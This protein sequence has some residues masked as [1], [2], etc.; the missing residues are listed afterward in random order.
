[1]HFHVRLDGTATTQCPAFAFG[2]QIEVID[3]IIAVVYQIS[4]ESC[5]GNCL[6][7]LRHVSQIYVQHI[8][9]T[10]FWSTVRNRLFFFHFLF[11]LRSF[12]LFGRF[13]GNIVIIGL[14]NDTLFYQHRNLE[15]IVTFYQCYVFSLKSSHDTA[16]HFTEETDF[17]SYFHRF[18]L[19]FIYNKT[20][21]FKKEL[22]LHTLSKEPLPSFKIPHK[23]T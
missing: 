4:I 12:R 7:I 14:N 5:R 11:R 3:E 21:L 8:V 13:K 20:A 23:N 18:I 6:Y 10:Y 15:A 2:R 17:I 19:L 22:Q 16:S 1:M 9:S